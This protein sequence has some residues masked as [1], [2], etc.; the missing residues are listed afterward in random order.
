MAAYNKEFMKEAIRI[1][2]DNV[3]DGTGGPFGAVVVRDGKIIATSGNTVVPDNDPTAHAEVNAIR[4]ACKQL[5]S[6]QL[7][8]CDIYSSCEPCP[9]CL[10]AI[11]WARPDHL[12]YASTKE[13][14][15]DGGFDDSFIY[16]EIALDGPDRFIPFI[17][18]REEGSGEEFRLWKENENKTVY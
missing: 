11:Y 4:K 3:K 10:G 15:A 5:D 17:N 9:M 2:L 14:A 18:K 8:G 1:A 12:Y 16:K 6:F 13:D 7:K